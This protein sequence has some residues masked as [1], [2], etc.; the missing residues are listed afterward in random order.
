MKSNI[1]YR[2]IDFHVE[3]EHTPGEDMTYDYPGCPEEAEIIRIWHKETD[4]TNF[5]TEDQ[6]IEIEQILLK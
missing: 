1:E 2:G 4:F 6:I 3:W 5:F